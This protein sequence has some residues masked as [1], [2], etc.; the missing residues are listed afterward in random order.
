MKTCVKMDESCCFFFSVLKKLSEFHTREKC[1]S[2]NVHGWKKNLGKICFQVLSQ[3][4]KLFRSDFF[5]IVT[6]P[7]GLLYLAVKTKQNTKDPPGLLPHLSS[8]FFSACR[9]VGEL[10][11]VST[12]LWSPSSCTGFSPSTSSLPRSAPSQHGS[13]AV[14]TRR[15]YTEQVHAWTYSVYFFCWVMWQFSL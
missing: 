12:R 7:S 10:C 9:W 11:P 2:R 3:E 14:R 1:F 8:S 4:R 5:K 15:I 6:C 13:P